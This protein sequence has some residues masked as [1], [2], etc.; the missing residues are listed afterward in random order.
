M[1]EERENR[2]FEHYLDGDS[3]ESRRYTALGDETPPAEIDAR[4]LAEAERAVK[5][6]GVDSRRAPPFKAFAWAAVV[7]LSFS[8][9]LN[10]VF[11]QAGRDPGAESE[12]PMAL[13]ADAPLP[14][15]KVSELVVTASK[16]ERA[17]PE[18]A[19]LEN[20][21]SG[22]R[23]K[24][25]PER[26]AADRD[27]RQHYLMPER[28]DAPVVDDLGVPEDSAAA[29]A[30]TATPSVALAIDRSGPGLESDEQVHASVMR[31]VADFVSKTS[32]AGRRQ[33]F[34]SAARDEEELTAELN[35]ILEN[36]HEGRFEDAEAKLAAFRAAYPK[37][38][39][40]VELAARGF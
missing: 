13:R 34:A 24:R 38:P 3:A 37:H 27:V 21:P 35:R 15:S 25:Q 9:V 40:S 6:T 18:A 16:A 12:A 36:Y 8:L 22:A 28:A 26:S 2:Q 14:E 19:G 17:S 5:V 29:G 1:H 32:N 39:V 23:G 4:I 10:I 30:R 33:G 11:R 31:V 7:V 20:G